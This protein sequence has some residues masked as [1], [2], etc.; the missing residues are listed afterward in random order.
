[1]VDRNAISD[2]VHDTLNIIQTGRW[3]IAEGTYDGDEKAAQGESKQEAIDSLIDR[4][5]KR[6]RRAEA[7]DERREH[8]R[9]MREQRQELADDQA[10]RAR[11][12]AERHRE[13]LDA[14]IDDH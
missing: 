6:E 11:E 13:T 5:Y 14:L 3:Y 9:R 10:R 12:A 1:M 4:F 2:A 8:R 7:R